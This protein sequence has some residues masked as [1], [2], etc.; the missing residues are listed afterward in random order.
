D[1][2]FDEPA[3]PM[4]FQIKPTRDTGRPDRSSAHGALPLTAG[5][6]A[7]PEKTRSLSDSVEAESALECGQEHTLTNLAT[8]SHR[9]QGIDFKVRWNCRARRC[10]LRVRG[11]RVERAH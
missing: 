8:T 3:Q 4:L 6:A 1:Q 11:T 9:L 7:A 10:E 5:L 2:T